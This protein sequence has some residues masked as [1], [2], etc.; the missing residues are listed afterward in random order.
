[1]LL[2]THYIH[3]L[4]IYT[5]K[6]QCN[7]HVYTDVS[8]S[9]TLFICVGKIRLASMASLTHF[10]QPFV[11]ESETDRKSKVEHY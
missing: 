8:I 7:N 9:K 6:P 1:M 3:T 2:A 11:V 5:A 10:H 4:Y